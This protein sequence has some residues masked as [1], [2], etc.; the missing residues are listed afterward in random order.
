M[1]FSQLKLP[2]KTDVRNTQKYLPV[3][4]GLVNLGALPVCRSNTGREYNTRQLKMKVIFFRRN[5]RKNPEILLLF[6][7]VHRIFSKFHTLFVRDFDQFF[8]L[9]HS[10][11]CFKY[12]YNET[13]KQRSDTWRTRWVYCASHW[14]GRWYRSGWIR[15]TGATKHTQT[16]SY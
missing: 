12:F 8:N 2:G 3:Y 4:L 11:H 9:Q 13:N 7:V 6:C 15:L 1:F 14:N 16:L 10:K 5:R